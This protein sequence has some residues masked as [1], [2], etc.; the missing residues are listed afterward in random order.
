M[1]S[2]A[3]R[4]LRP[5]A[6]T[7]REW[8][9]AGQRR[10]AVPVNLAIAG[11]HVDAFVHGDDGL[12]AVHGW[13]EDLSTFARELRLRVDHTD[14]PPSHV[15]RVPRSDLDGAVGSTHG[16]R[17]AVAE[18][19]IEAQS[20][21]VGATLLVSERAVATIPLATT[22]A[23][24]YSHLHTYPHVVG[25][26]GI[27]AFGP[28]SAVVSEEV[29]YL[30]RT[31]P[32][33]VLDFGCGAGALIAALRRHGIEAYGIELDN[34]RIRGSLLDAAR[35]FVTLYDGALPSPFADR[36]FRSVICSEVLEHIPG[37][38]AG[39]AEIVRVAAETVL[40]TVPDMSAIAR[41]FSHHVVPWHLLE[42][43]HVNFF[44]QHSLAALL[45]PH[46]DDIEF[47]RLGAVQCNRM[48]YYDS[49]AARVRL[50]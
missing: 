20:A 12:V 16:F 4:W 36:Q 14:R 34:E 31:L 50:R 6:R 9:A 27:Y 8:L 49:L 48:L 25:R 39:L 29:L 26:E 7:A 45:A 33:P 41:G 44:T 10:T 40:I 1:T 5:W 32:G 37:P 19:A 17:G 15:F 22:S 43:T 38:G 13:C 35:P 3:K 46:A 28:P 30:A 21:P 23:V 42:S 18:W 47:S 24:P 2:I 11:G